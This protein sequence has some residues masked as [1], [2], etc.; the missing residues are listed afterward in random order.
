[1]ARLGAMLIDPCAYII[2]HGGC[3][4]GKLA[5]LA[6]HFNFGNHSLLIEDKSNKPNNMLIIF[7][8]IKRTNVSEGSQSGDHPK[9]DF[10]ILAIS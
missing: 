3:C 8:N 1:V 9:I 2:H 10:A 4:W 7:L 6:L 5:T